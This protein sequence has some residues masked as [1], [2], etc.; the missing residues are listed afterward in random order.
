MQ[1]PLL[2]VPQHP[3]QNLPPAASAGLTPTD[4][5]RVGRSL[6]SNVSENT[7]KMYASAWHSF[8]TWAQ[9]RGN[10]SLPASAQLAAAYLSHLA[11]ERRLSVA[12]I[13]LHKVALSAMHKARGH[14]DPTENEGVRRMIERIVRAQGESQH[15]R[16]GKPGDSG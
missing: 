2:P 13:R 7:R 9:A 10:L 6:D 15:Q 5:Q 11:E 14:Q 16:I 1:N 4:I 12:T 8:E 3:E